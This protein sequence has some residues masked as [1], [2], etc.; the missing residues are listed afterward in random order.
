[1]HDIDI[2]YTPLSPPPRAQMPAYCL[3][4][5]RLLPG[6]SYCLLPGII[7]YLP[8]ILY[9]LLSTDLND[10]VASGM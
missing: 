2:E 1:M 9:Y 3:T 10:T 7:Y 4:V 8:G 6:I 5:Y